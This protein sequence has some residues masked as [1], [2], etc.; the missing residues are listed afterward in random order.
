MTP[1]HVIHGN[2][3]SDIE[4]N[5][6]LDLQRD[7]GQ[8][9]GRMVTLGPEAGQEL[10]GEAIVVGTPLSS[11]YVAALCERGKLS[12]DLERPGPQASRLRGTE[13]GVL[14]LAGGD[15]KAAQRAVY[16]FC[17]RELGVDPFAWWT[18][19]QPKPQP[20]FRVP[21]IDRFLP[22]PAVPVLCYFD[23]DNDELANMSQPFL[24][25]DIETWMAL[26]DSLTRIGYNA[27]DIHDHLGRSEFYRWDFYKN[28]RPD[29]RVDFDL[30]NAVIDHAHSKGMMVQA[31]MYLAWHFMSITE[32]EANCWTRFKDRWV[33][34]WEYYMTDTPIG[35]CDIFLDRPRSQLW[36][37]H[38][39]SS[40]DEDTA[41]VMTEAFTA[42]RDVVLKHN[43]NALLVCDLYTHGQDVWRTGRF[44][45]PKDYI[46][47]WPN[48]GWGRFEGFPEDKRGY[49]FG[50]Y[51]HAGY[52]LNHVV[53]D[54]YPTR[55]EE[56]MRELLLRHDATHYCL[57]NGQ[58]FRHFLLN[59]EAYARVV[60]DPVGMVG[61][62][63]MRAFCTRYFGEAAA[64]HAVAALDLLHGVSGQGYVRLLHWVTEA[65]DLLVSGNPPAS[66][67]PFIERRD[68]E[69]VRTARLGE[70]LAEAERAT[71][72]ADDQCGFCHDYVELPVRLFLQTAELHRALLDAILNGERFRASGDPAA[73]DA[74]NAA[75]DSA[76]GLLREHLETRETGD[77]NPKWKTW[78][79]PAKRR[80][81]GGFPDLATI[82]SLRF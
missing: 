82:E 38:Y 13:G 55:I 63:F 36:D 58:T 4:R 62:D 11:D 31:P 23:N 67:A 10:T 37:T 56:S 51:M 29:Y 68:T 66:F 25:F 80:P 12:F 27:V 76:A 47:A 20:A 30:L 5:A 8:V 33:E 15:S 9:T 48:N 14:T 74:A 78:Y 3:A 6:C 44:N 53:Q 28:L 64:P 49:R 21:D 52:W 81:N 22:P 59:I 75:L 7:L 70:A 61:E 72:L 45:P 79:D 1:I 16:D 19:Y 60:A 57:V 65:Q 40:C 43:P 18:G 35:R 50:A 34:T 26:I 71:A 46:M 41:T 39:Q 32:E 73:R 2:R 17:T 42:L 54:P 24:Q 69:G 77:R